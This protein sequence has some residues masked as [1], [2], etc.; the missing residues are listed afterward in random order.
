MIF[1]SIPEHQ[2]VNEILVNSGFLSGRA[3]REIAEFG[4]A[5]HV[6]SIRNAIKMM[7][8]EGI[9]GI[10]ENSSGQFFVELRISGMALQVPKNFVD[11]LH[12]FDFQN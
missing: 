5:F 8:G 12:W 6:E 7:I 3:C 2:L 4:E 1:S 10:N 9:L 11:F